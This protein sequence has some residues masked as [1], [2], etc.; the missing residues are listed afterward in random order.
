MTDPQ[1]DP[2]PQTFPDV[3]RWPRPV[4]RLV[5][6]GLA[7]LSWAVVATIGYGAWRFSAVRRGLEI[8]LVSMILTAAVRLVVV[9]LWPHWRKQPSR[10]V[11]TAS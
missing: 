10:S 5:Q 2:H 9:G 4:R 1:P 6:F 11:A 7:G 8:V 3:K